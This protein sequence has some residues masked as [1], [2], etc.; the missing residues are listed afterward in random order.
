MG[1]TVDISY[2]LSAGAAAV[3]VIFGVLI[4]R[5]AGVF[6]CLIRTKLTGRERLFCMIAYMPKATV[7]AAIGSLPLSM[8]LPCGKDVYKRQIYDRGRVRGKGNE[9]RPGGLFSFQAGL[10]TSFTRFQVNSASPD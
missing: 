4:F 9:N 3:L 6:C 8:G 10:L 5:M 1:A 2:A 7:Q